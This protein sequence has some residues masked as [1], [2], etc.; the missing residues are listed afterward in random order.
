MKSRGNATRAS[1][2]IAWIIHG[3]SSAECAA[4]AAHTLVMISVCALDLYWYPAQLPWWAAFGVAGVAGVIGLTVVD[5]A[6]LE[7]AARRA[8][9]RARRG[10]AVMHSRALLRALSPYLVAHHDLASTRV[11]N[12]WSA[13]SKRQ[14]LHQW[15]L[16]ACALAHS[17]DRIASDSRLATALGGHT[18]FTQSDRADG[19]PVDLVLDAVAALHIAAAAERGSPRTRVRWAQLD[20]A[21]EGAMRCLEDNVHA[22]RDLPNASDFDEQSKRMAVHRRAL[23]RAAHA[24]GVCVSKDWLAESAVDFQARTRSV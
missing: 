15:L 5:D 13:A 9:R 20:H 4:I 21:F 8:H 10:L 23:T 18:H 2:V 3:A 22:L 1:I 24:H 12:G 16:E 14:S 19:R 7:Q 17:L 11:F 6:R